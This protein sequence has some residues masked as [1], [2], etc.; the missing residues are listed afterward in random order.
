MEA[1]K[2]FSRSWPALFLAPQVW[3]DKRSS[4]A[5]VSSVKVGTVLTIIINNRPAFTP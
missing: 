4:K 2:Y 1:A 3:A 5:T